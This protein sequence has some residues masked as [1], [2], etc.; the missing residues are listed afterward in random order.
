MMKGN[1]DMP[2]YQEVR[3]LTIL[4]FYAIEIEH[5]NRRYVLDGF[6]ADD[7]KVAFNVA[8]RAVN[9]TQRYNLCERLRIAAR[10]LFTGKYR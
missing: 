10:V 9:K 8:L 1:K 2:K 5:G 4:E 7:C 6:T 3:T